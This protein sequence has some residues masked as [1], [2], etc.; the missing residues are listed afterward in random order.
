MRYRLPRLEFF[1]EHGLDAQT[2]KS[3]KLIILAVAFGIINFNI[4]NGIAMAGYLRALGASDFVYGLLFAIAPLFAPMQLA[5]SY[6]LER[7]KARKKIL[8]TAGLIH[9]AVWLP[10][11]L[12]PFF[13]PLD[14]LTLRIWMAALFMI[15]S[16]ST[17]PFMSVSFFSL[18]ADIVPENIRGRYF[19]VRMKISTICGIIGGIL[20]AW[21][22]DSFPVFYSFALV[23]TLAAFTGVMDMVCFFGVK[24]PEMAESPKD[25]DSFFQML[26]EVIKNKP[27]F[28][29]I[30]FMTL[31]LFSLNLSA[32]FILI[33][34]RE[35]V[36][37]S[38]TLIVIGVQILPNICSVMIVSRWGRA[39]DSHGNKVVMQVANGLL[40]F[41]PFLWILTTNNSL[42][43]VLIVAIGL[44]TG[45][46]LPGFDLGAN[47]IMLGN[48]PK[49]NRSMYIAM[50]FT[51]TSII[52]I[53]LANATGG[54]LLDNVFSV[55]EQMGL[56]LFGVVLNRY[57]YILA[58]SAIMRCVIV[59][60]ALPRM[61][62]D[63]SSKTTAWQLLKEIRWGI[64]KRFRRVLF[65]VRARRLR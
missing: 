47:N 38:N 32:P 25:E 5:A 50:Y 23:F 15:V 13:I 6:L 53:A 14:N 31:W 18:A 58:L 12:I 65:M 17:G 56:S 27:Y 35:Y 34:L 29:F 3:L 44:M 10:F 22:L 55:P 8:I 40:C 37:L 57:N 52:G 19:A 42:S 62:R 63:E 9:R 51:C 45:L 33:H 28:R 59:Y 7:T 49:V 43:I 21:M 36:H 16:A 39:L 64:S 54:W 1:D 26:K 4:V 61:V 30:V 60:I 11:G 20:T 24:S 46:L 48:A 2:I 41:A